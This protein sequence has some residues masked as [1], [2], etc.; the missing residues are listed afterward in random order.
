MN[1]LG[2][3]FNDYLGIIILEQAMISASG[4]YI[5]TLNA[6]TY[7]MYQYKKLLIVSP[8]I[9]RIGDPLASEICENSSILLAKNTARRE[10]QNLL[11]IIIRYDQFKQA[12][13]IIRHYDS[14]AFAIS[15]DVN[16]MIGEGFKT[17]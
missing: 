7:R 10:E 12:R 17:L 9:N 3:K 4:L 13:D 14:H 2:G 6:M 15:P 8:A 5:L 1:F 11:M 16:E